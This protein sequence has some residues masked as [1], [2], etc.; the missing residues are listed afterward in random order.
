MNSSSSTEKPQ[1]SQPNDDTKVTRLRHTR[2]FHPA[3]QASTT[4][5]VE[6][7]VIA[8]AA[9]EVEQHSI[10]IGELKGNLIK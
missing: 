7:T 9:E 4:R 5:F 3:E 10:E 2:S 8:I 1:L 6:L